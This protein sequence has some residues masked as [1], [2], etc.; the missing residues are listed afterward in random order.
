MHSQKEESR[1]DLTS[2]T[3]SSVSSSTRRTVAS[4]AS[5]AATK[6]RAKA[7]ALKVKNAYVERE[8]AML[9]EKARIEEQ[10]QRTLAEAERNKA[11]VEADLKVLQSEREAAAASKKAEVYE[12][13]A[14]LGEER[15]SNFGEEERAQRTR[16][17]VQNHTPTNNAQQSFPESQHAPIELI[18]PLYQ[19]QT[20]HHHGSYPQHAGTSFERQ[21]NRATQRQPATVPTP[22]VSSEG[23]THM[24]P[25]MP[26]FATYMIRREMVSSGLTQFDDRPENYWAWKTSFQ[27]ITCDLNLTHREEL[28]LLVKWLGPESS[29]QA[30]RIS[31]GNHE[32]ST[33]AEM[34][35]VLSPAMLLT[36]KASIAPAPPGDFKVDHLHKSQWRQVQSLADCFWK[37]WRQEFLATLQPRR[38][39]AEV[40]PNL[41]EGDVVLLRDCQVKRNEWPIGL[42]TK[43]MPS[44]DDRV[45]KVMVKTVKQGTV[46]EYLRPINELVVLL[47]KVDC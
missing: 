40:R 32:L 28:D 8:A 24:P 37:R 41:Q 26:D 13:A 21:Q 12:A 27:N 11:D 10:Q 31:H 20:P 38:K 14:D 42:I 23:H 46:K 4:S 5:S 15:R 6:A 35:Q 2:E 45:R 22:R 7:E 18:S 3:R 44:S 16:E 30:K 36:Q 47:P 17:Y 9:K 29:T 39:W 34:P 33:D 43:T 19:F 1:T 25:Q